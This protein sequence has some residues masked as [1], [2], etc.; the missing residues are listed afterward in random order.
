MIFETD[1][2]IARP[3][4]LDDADAALKMYGDPEVMRYL[5]RN[6][7]GATIASIKEMR[8]RL[9]KAIDKYSATDDGFIYAAIVL[10]HSREPIGT[11]LLK[12]L[13][14]ASGESADEIEIGWHL[15]RDFWGKGLGTE[16]A[17]GV[18]RY[19][20]DRLAVE[21]L[22]AIAYPENKSSLRIMQKIGMTYQGSTDRFYGVTA[23][24]YVISRTRPTS[25]P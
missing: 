20:F 22:H 10:K 17:F 16:C 24:H 23:E 21:E 14:L 15:A 9:G 12:P 3:W 11:A 4:T 7:A 1:R 5:G 18:M 25:H 19:G 6:G 2:L 8:E 13:E